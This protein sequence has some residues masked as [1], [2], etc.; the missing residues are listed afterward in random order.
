VRSCSTDKT[1]VRDVIEKLEHDDRYRTLRKVEKRAAPAKER[2]CGNEE[3]EAKQIA[4]RAI[5]SEAVSTF[6]ATPALECKRL[7]PLLR[8]RSDQKDIEAFP[9]TGCRRVPSETG[10]AMMAVD[11]RNAELGV[12]R[13]HQH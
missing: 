12:G 7:A 4:K 11:M 5:V 13:P 8:Q 1:V 9:K 10:K 3:H 6:G 2:E